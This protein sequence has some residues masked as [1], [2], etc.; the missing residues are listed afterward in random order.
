MYITDY[1]VQESNIDTSDVVDLGLSVKWC[2]CNLGATKPEEYGEYYRWANG[3]NG[4]SLDG[5]P[6][7]K[8]IAGTKFDVAYLLSEGKLKTPTRK[9]FKELIDRCRWSWITYNG[10]TGCK[11]T[12]PSG[13]SIFCQAQVE[14][15]IMVS[16][17][18]IPLAIIG[19][20][21]GAWIECLLFILQ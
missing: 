4:H 2:G 20:Q 8:E 13:K 10:T 3:M 17:V 5:F 21:V 18:K 14:R 1:M 12:G 7:D 16:I 9:Q 15:V 19:V 11:V 6:T